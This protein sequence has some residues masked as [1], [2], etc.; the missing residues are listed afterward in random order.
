[1]RSSAATGAAQRLGD[2]RAGLLAGRVALVTGGGT[3]LGKA[4]AF[5]LARCG[6][7]VM[8]TGRRQEVLEQACGCE[9]ERA[10]AGCGRPRGARSRGTC[11]EAPCVT[12][13]IAADSC[14]S[15][16][17]RPPRS[18]RSA[19]EQRRRAVLQPGG[20]DR[21]EGLARGVAAERRGDAEHV[22]GGLRARVSS[23]GAWRGRQRHALAASRDARDGALAARRAR[24]WRR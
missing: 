14:W 2:L 10:I 5:E 7:T 9:L 17:A 21:A 19:R 3:G 16:G 23:G 1:M 4:T 22:R 13:E 18:P 20:A 8:I 11:E 12:L 6:A 24:P 15:D